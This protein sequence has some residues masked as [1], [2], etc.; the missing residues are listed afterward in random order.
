MR[1]KNLIKK[2]KNVEK[3]KA[4]LFF[5]MCFAVYIIITAKS[6]CVCNH[7]HNRKHNYYNDNHHGNRNC[8]SCGR[9]NS[10]STSISV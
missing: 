10:G 5:Q 8:K 7:I 6:I 3:K 1:N 4:S 2:H 9:K